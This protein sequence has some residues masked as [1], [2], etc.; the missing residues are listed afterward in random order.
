MHKLIFVILVIY[1][2][3]AKAQSPQAVQAYVDRYKAVAIEEMKIYGIPASVTLAQGIH[4]SGCGCSALALNS[5]NHFGIKCH[6]EWSGQTYHHDDDQPQECFRVY[7][8]PEE[9]FRD[10]SEFLKNRPRYAS[11]FNLDHN[12]YRGWARGLKAAGYATNPRYPEIIIGLIETYNLTQFDKAG[13]ENA[14]V[15]IKT[16]PKTT[17][18]IDLIKQSLLQSTSAAPAIH[19]PVAAVT[20]TS[21][22]V[23]AEPKVN[24]A[25]PQTVDL[26]KYVADEKTINGSKALIYKKDMPLAFVAHKYNITMQQLYAY[27]DMEA[28]DKFNENEMVYVEKKRSESGAFQH[29]VAAGETMHDIAQEYGIQLPALNARN[30]LIAGCEPVPGEIIVLRGKRDY[31]LKFR[32]LGKNEADKTSVQMAPVPAVIPEAKVHTVSTSE[33]LYSISREYNIPLDT[34]KRINGLKDEDIK[35]GQTLIVNL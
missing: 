25:P 21:A 26:S 17:A 16:V 28:G 30:G 23:I 34:L 1:I 18:E 13:G 33:T 32:V 14:T 35:I 4:E 2:T 19:V 6:E 22:P 8:C 9:S 29:E 11:L 27:N 3:A 31:P 20:K 5:N 15:S 7:T 12:D 10:H 24:T